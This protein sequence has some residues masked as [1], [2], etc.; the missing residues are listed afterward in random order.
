LNYFSFDP[1]LAWFILGLAFLVVEACVPGLFILFFGL[2]AWSAAMAA[3]AGL[4]FT[5]QVLVFIAMTVVSL[6]LLR[7]KLKKLLAARS[8][9]GEEA[10]DPVVA[11]QYLGREVM[12][13]AEAAPGRPTLVE[14]NGANWQARVEGEAPVRL[15][16]RV[17]V[18][19]R[20]NLTL[21]V[22]RIPP[23]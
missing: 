6:A 12:V 20:D 7:S 1:A 3:L 22:A 5:A 23:S 18:V 11:A 16:D 9:R 17:R 4:G 8:G 14:F 2:G 21:V 19:G 13:V 10:D 15:G